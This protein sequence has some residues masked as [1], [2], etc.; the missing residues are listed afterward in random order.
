V[1]VY[2]EEDKRTAQIVLDSKLHVRNDML[3]RRGVYC[4]VWDASLSALS[5]GIAW[6]GY[7]A[8]VSHSTSGP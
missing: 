6:V 2:Q 1:R 4:I 8:T 7:V 5:G 3:R